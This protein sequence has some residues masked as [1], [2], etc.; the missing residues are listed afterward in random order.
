M[1]DNKTNPILQTYSARMTGNQFLYQEFKVICGLILQGFSKKELAQKI[2][3]ENLFNYRS[4]KAINKHIGAVFERVNYLDDNLKN[5]VINQSNEIGRL[6]NFYSILKYDLLF[7]EFMSEVIADKLRTKQYILNKS[8][9]SHFFSIKA[10]QSDI[11]AN[12]KD[13]TLKRLR[14][15]YIECLIGAGYINQNSTIMD[16]SVPFAIYQIRNDIDE[17]YIKAMAGG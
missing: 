14:L 9:I 11:V 17:P 13:S 12:F 2:V 7:F 5:K 15:A 1:N 6:I 8:D 3:D 10:Q 16:I 4:M